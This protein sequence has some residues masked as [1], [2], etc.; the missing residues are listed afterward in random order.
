MTCLRVGS[1]GRCPAKQKVALT[2]QDLPGAQT[3]PLPLKAAGVK[4][5]K[6]RAWVLETPWETGLEAAVESPILK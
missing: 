6:D 3:F 2:L 5:D 4:D 1:L